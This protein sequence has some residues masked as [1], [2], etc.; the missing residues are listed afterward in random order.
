VKHNNCD[1]SPGFSK[2]SRSLL[3]VF[4]VF[5]L[6]W[7]WQNALLMLTLLITAVR[8]RAQVPLSQEEQCR[9][10]FAFHGILLHHT[11]WSHQGFVYK[12]WSFQPLWQKCR[13]HNAF[14]LY[15]SLWCA[16]CY[17]LFLLPKVCESSLLIAEGDEDVFS[18]QVQLDVLWQ[19]LKFTHKEKTN[20]LPLLA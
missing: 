13:L 5:L 9:K 7:I 19:R 12:K 11:V 18:K 20:A 4:C 3:H 15:F 2:T 6:S 17:M 1:Y 10:V 8:T 16:K 14:K